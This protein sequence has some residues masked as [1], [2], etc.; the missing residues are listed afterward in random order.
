MRKIITVILVAMIMIS[1]NSGDDDM[2]D[3]MNQQEQEE[4]AYAALG[5]FV[6]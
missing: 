5:R 2:T 4:N 6:S 3:A 1:C